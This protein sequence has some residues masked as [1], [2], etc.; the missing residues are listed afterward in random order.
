ML[1]IIIMIGVVRMFVNKAKEKNLPHV[2]WGIIGA[3]SYYVPIILTSFVIMPALVQNDTIVF[4]SESQVYVT[5][6][7]TNL[8]VGVSCC[9]IAY[10]VLK[11]LDSGNEESTILDENV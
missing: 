4:T 9:I 5:L 8:A 2:L 10:Q 7:L 6:L 11:R 1:E 3:A